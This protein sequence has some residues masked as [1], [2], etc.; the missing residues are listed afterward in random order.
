ML[1][2]V[3]LI[4]IY[5]YIVLCVDVLACCICVD[6]L[7]ALYYHPPCCSYCFC[8]LL[9]VDSMLLLCV[10][11]LKKYIYYSHISLLFLCYPHIHSF[12]FHVAR[13]RLTTLSDLS[14]RRSV[15]HFQF[16]YL[17]L[18]MCCFLFLS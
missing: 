8:F 11:F 10:F 4:Y 3:F 12:H 1:I 15:F 7:V 5:I 6:V 9:S 18:V 14:V 16:V 13:R 2:L 17:S